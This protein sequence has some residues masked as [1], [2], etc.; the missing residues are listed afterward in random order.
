MCKI[1]YISELGVTLYL[2]HIKFGQIY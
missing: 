2:G 1:V